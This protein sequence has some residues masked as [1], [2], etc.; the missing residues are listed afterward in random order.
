MRPKAANKPSLDPRLVLRAG[1]KQALNRLLRSVGY[2]P[3]EQTLNDLALA[4]RRSKPLLLGGPRGAGKT[5]IAE[6]LAEAFN[7]P[8]YYIPGHEGIDAADVMGRWDRAEQEITVRHAVAA[9]LALAE[10]RRAKW[11]W[12]FYEAGEFLD[13][14]KEAQRAAAAGEPPPVLLIDETEK[15]P[16]ELQHVLLQPLARGFADVPKLEGIVG[17]ENPSHR[18]IVILTSNDLDKLSEP[19]TSRCF[20]T[21]VYPPTPQEEIRILRARVPDAAPET[22]AAVASMVNFIRDEMPEIRNDPGI[23]ESR[24]LLEALVEDG[25][26]QITTE[27]V[28][29][30]L[31]CIGKGKKEQEVLRQ[32]DDG[33]AWAAANPDEKI[34][35][36]TADAFA[37]SSLAV[38]REAA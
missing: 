9:G 17:V 21:W 37:S 12:D 38:L 31:A 34:L 36:W 10:A 28:R 2:V 35:G 5:A 11:D 20:V 19:L 6:D 14:Y 32:N 15:L 23:R 16:V 4:L 22:L 30:Y 27:T 25:V 18:P 8:L 1:G 29:E 7:L 26:S 33:L 3:Q 24:D 13:A